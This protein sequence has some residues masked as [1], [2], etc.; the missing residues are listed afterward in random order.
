MLNLHQIEQTIVISVEAVSKTSTI[1]KVKMDFRNEL[2]QLRSRFN[3]WMEVPF[4][5]PTR[6]VFNLSFVDL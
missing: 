2:I 6:V 4:V 3:E 5:L 1:Y